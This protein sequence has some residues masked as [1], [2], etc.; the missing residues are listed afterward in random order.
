LAD[1]QLQ[2]L[3]ESDSQLNQWRE[4]IQTAVGVNG[5][6]IIEVIPEVELIIGSQPT[7]PI[8]GPTKTQ[9]RF[10]TVFQNFIHLFCQP[11]YPLILFLDD[12][13]WADIASLNFLELLMNDTDLHHLLVL[14]AYRD[15]EVN[16]AHPLLLTRDRLRA[17]GVVNQI[18]MPSNLPKK[19][20]SLSKLEV[21]KISLL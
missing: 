18:A 16:P 3:T 19:E 14:G 5:Q 8:L 7:V 6:V 21:A 15:N 9:N 1:W 11:A 2:L 13:Q 10:N 12:L 4:Q 20:E 17:N